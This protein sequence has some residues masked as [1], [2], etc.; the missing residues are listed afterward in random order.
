M[1]GTGEVVEGVLCAACAVDS[2]W[3]CDTLALGHFAP[4][5]VGQ[6]VVV[7]LAGLC[8]NGAGGDDEGGDVE[9]HSRRS[10]C[11]CYDPEHCQLVLS[12]RSQGVRAI[13]LRDR[14]ADQGDGLVKPDLGRTLGIRA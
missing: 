9:V 14:R 10:G 2:R 3:A 4:V 5:L 7:Q 12:C 11:V 8:A 6:G 1:P 13:P